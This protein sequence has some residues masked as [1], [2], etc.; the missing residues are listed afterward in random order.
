MWNEK[1]TALSGVRD[2]LFEQLS[3]KISEEG[4]NIHTFTRHLWA[5]VMQFSH[6]TLDGGG[7]TQ[8]PYIKLTG[9]LKSGSKYSSYKSTKKIGKGDKPS[10]DQ[11]VNDITI[12]IDPPN[13]E[14]YISRTEK[15]KLVI[16]KAGHVS[17]ILSIHGE[18]EDGIELIHSYNIRVKLE[19]S[20]PSSIKIDIKPIKC[21]ADFD[22]QEES[23]DDNKGAV[24]TK[25]KKSTKS[26]PK[27]K[28]KITLSAKPSEIE[29][30]KATVPVLKEWLN[31][32]N[33]KKLPKRKADLIQRIKKTIGGDVEGS[34]EQDKNNYNEL[35]KHITEN[36][37]EQLTD[38]HE[39][40]L[41][42]ILDEIYEVIDSKE[43]PKDLEYDDSTYL[44][45]DTYLN[46]L[47]K[48]T[49]NE[50][51]NIPTKGGKWNTK[52]IIN[53]IVNYM[54]KKY[55]NKYSPTKARDVT[56]YRNDGRLI[57]IPVEISELN[58]MLDKV[59]SATPSGLGKKTR[60]KYQTRKKD[61]KRKTRR[62]R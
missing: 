15:T 48:D 32:R 49:N 53:D 26:K 55:Y 20:P 47:S 51:Y 38:K 3:N 27:T 41:Q 9:F 42:N 33:E 46:E 58:N 28:P 6:A 18:S 39:A 57:E 54:K 24:L 8:L 4:E 35:I 19:S 12:D 10:I 44:S 50:E 37:Q 52:Q 40:V 13:I 11:C 1:L 7:D 61:K 2:Y 23:K 16:K 59:I 17:I 60:R 62:N 34:G 36:I 22:E 29:L 31:I 30:N 45:D 5:G 56:W 14:N 43:Y 25:S 21:G